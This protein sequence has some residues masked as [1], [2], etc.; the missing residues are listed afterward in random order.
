LSRKKK[1][2]SVLRDITPPFIWATLRQ[3]FGQ[4]FPDI[5]SVNY[6][7]VSTQH[8]MRC[9]HEGYFA[10]LYDRY[11]TLNPNNS[12]NLT[13]LRIYNACLFAEFARAVPGDY[14]SAGISYGIAPRIIFD[15][16]KFWQLSKAYHFVDPFTGSNNPADKK[17][18]P[19][20]EDVSFVIQQYPSNAAI[21][22]H[23]AL[24]P[25]CFP[26][27]D[28]ELLAFVHLNVT[29][30]PSEA[31][32]LSYLYD[33]LSPGGFILIDYYGYGTGQYE[34]FDPVE[35]QL[36]IKIFSMVTGQGVIQKPLDFVSNN[37]ES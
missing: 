22:I 17:N 12:E 21:K 6:Q 7:G 9:L 36:G 15:F 30:P 16:V 8:S 20:N 14:L 2:L 31:A 13:R 28:I 26:I 5:A 24:I 25:N 35:D 1:L 37:Y 4:Y 11:R 10:Q 3:R 33:K 18:H 34:W 32:S 19:Y 23:K 27:D 29:H